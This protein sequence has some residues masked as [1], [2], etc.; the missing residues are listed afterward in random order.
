MPSTPA[1]RRTDAMA[2]L[3]VKDLHTSFHTRAGVVRA[4]QDLSFHLDAGE[5]LGIVGES[6]SGK[7]V[8]M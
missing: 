3:E 5:T 4:V 1:R 2:L 6:C 8:A 7:S